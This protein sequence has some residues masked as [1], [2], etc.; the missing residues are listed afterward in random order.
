MSHGFEVSY[1]SLASVCFHTKKCGE[2][3]GEKDFV[4][5]CSSKRGA[6]HS[7]SHLTGL[8]TLLSQLTYSHTKE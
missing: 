4:S 2:F 1:Y 8:L 3:E 7:T 5:F 6:V